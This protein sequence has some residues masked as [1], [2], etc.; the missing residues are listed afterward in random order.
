[1]SA[2][3]EPVS[4]AA[5]FALPRQPLQRRYELLRAFFHEGLS[6]EDVAARFGC[7]PATV[8]A[9]ARD[10]RG[11]AD[12]ADAFF[13][14]PPRRGRSPQPLDEAL[15]QRILALRA[16]R[17]SVPDIKA[18]LDALGPGAPSER[19]I[20]RLL[21]EAGLARLPR[22]TRAERAVQTAS[23]RSAP[24]SRL[25]DA[26]GQEKF[27]SERAAGI[28]CLLPWLRH[29]GLDTLLEEAGYPDSE[30]LPP[31]PSVLAVLALKLSHV[32]RYSADDAW[33]IDRGLGLFAGLNVLPK[34]AWFS[35][36]AARVTPAMNQRLLGSLAGLWSQ[37]ELA[38]ASANLDFATLPHWGDDATLQERWRDSRG[39]ALQGLAVAL[40]QDPDSG[41]LLHADAGVRQ[42]SRAD[43]VLEFLDFS[44]RHGPP[45]RY[46]VFESRFATYSQLARLDREG[47]RFVTLRRQGQRLLACAEDL[48]LAKCQEVRVPLDRGT[49]VV[50]AHD[51][52]A[53]LRV[54]DGALRQ[55]TVLRGG[56][57][58]PA[59]LLTNDYD[60]SLADLLR[61]YARRWLVEQPISEQ[62]S[63]FHLN[64][65]A[66]SIVIKVDF[67]LTLTVL[68]SN[69]YRLFARDLP[70]GFRRQTAQALFETILETGADIQLAP[71][72]CRISLR[73]KRNLPML[74]E[75]LA[76]L[77]ATSVPWLGHRRLVFDGATRT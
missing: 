77:P 7:T 38:G 60:S 3:P 55:I 6:A 69:L 50:V 27:Q 71:G 40:A 65:R 56:H 72:L 45:M 59:T 32:Q 51:T 4:P 24:E 1:M 52:T 67:D 33:C 21:K 68:A 35:S 15:R 34:T 18:R 36:Y 5:F 76:R 11:L 53:R 47:I 62:L 43:S 25:L 66:S 23:P 9:L 49:R 19:A 8:Y 26:A 29:Y 39:P 30:S 14:S 12:P 10:F 54:Y 37:H 61:R 48:P 63:F 2:P 46:L 57:R 28:L 75:A 22:R 73:K 17:L 74:L 58:R 44:R 20:G 16:E 64:R 70:P 42:E 31:L 41:L 13:R